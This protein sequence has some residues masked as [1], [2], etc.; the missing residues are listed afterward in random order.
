M[1]GRRAVVIAAGDLAHVGPAFDTPPV[2]PGRLVLLKDADDELVSAMCRG[3][4]QQ[5]LQAIESVQDANN[6][7]GVSPIYLTLRLLAAAAAGSQPGGSQPSGSQPDGARLRLY[8]TPHGYA[9]CPADEAQT[10]VVTVCGVT[11]H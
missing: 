10:S 1:R 3:S 6:V 8:G 9:V 2:D 5:F 4:A 11:L 7:C